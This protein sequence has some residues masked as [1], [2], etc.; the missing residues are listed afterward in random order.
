MSLLSFL[1]IRQRA[2]EREQSSEVE[3]QILISFHRFIFPARQGSGPDASAVQQIENND[4]GSKEA[5]ARKPVAN[6]GN[7]LTKNHANTEVVRVTNSSMPVETALKPNGSGDDTRRKG[8]KRGRGRGRG[9]GG[10]RKNGGGGSGGKKE[11]DKWVSAVGPYPVVSPGEKKFTLKIVRFLPTHDLKQNMFDPR[12][13][14]VG[15]RLLVPSHAI[16]G[17][18]GKMCRARKMGEMGKNRNI[19][20]KNPSL[21]TPTMLLLGERRFLLSEGRRIINLLV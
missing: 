5:P 12:W 21:L 20:P 10:K 3:L 17:T 16:V 1:A 18:A 8:S 6:N 2:R 19:S 7:D 4:T 11:S 13:P 14:L 15:A 9:R